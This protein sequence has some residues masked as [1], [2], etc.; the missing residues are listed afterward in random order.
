MWMLPGSSCRHS[1]LTT[2][3]AIIIH[4]NSSNCRILLLT[5]TRSYRGAAFLQAAQKLN[6]ELVQAVHMPQKLAT[7][8]DG[9][10]SLDFGFPEEAVQEI[11]TYAG[12]HPLQAIL[13]VD[14]SGSLL[15]AR[16]G[17]ALNLPHNSEKA[18]GAA[19]DKYQMRRILATAPVLSPK[20]VRYA[21]GQDPAIIARETEFPCVVKPLKLNG[22]RGVIRANNTAEL[23]AAIERTTSLIRSLQ[24]D[25]VPCHFLV[26]SYIPGIEVALE[27]LLENGELQVLALFDKPDPLEGPYFEE[28]I[29]VTPSRL[30]AESQEDI[31]QTAAAAASAI[32]LRVGPIHAEMRL[33]EGGVW[34]VEI[35]GR[36]IGGLCSRTLQFGAGDSLEELILRQACGLPLLDAQQVD[37]ARGVMMIP[38]PAAGLLRAVEGVEMAKSHPLIDQ[39]EITA[40]L[41]YPLIPLPDGD[42]YLG[43]IF[44]RGDSPQSVEDALRWAHT[45]LDF[46]IDP[47]IPLMQI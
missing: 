26:E 30:P 24:G 27:G 9:G 5:T 36:S 8:W 13:A 4:V 2:P 44:A 37:E 33:N 46:K 41:N 40:K 11:I 25:D 19:R 17:A 31:K 45:E 32:G 35:A 22:S 3:K 12:A 28:T 34:I 23:T 14:D 10:F 20:S 39:I 47:V 21:A 16:A 7:T 1:P 42:G 18:A 38:I 43:F 6:I 29:Y 15:A